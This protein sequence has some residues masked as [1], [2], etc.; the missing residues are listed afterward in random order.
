MKRLLAFLFGLSAMCGSLAADDWDPNDDSF[1]PSIQS[2]VIGDSSWLGDPSPFLFT[3]L[4]R[5]GYTHV[6]QVNW[7]GFD[8][9]VQ[10]SLMVPQKDGETEPPSGGMLLLNGAQAV[11]LI[12]ILEAA[13]KEDPKEERISIKTGMKEADWAL[14]GTIEDRQ[15]FIQLESKSKDQVD[16]YRFSINASKKLLGAIR[17]SLEKLE[18]TPTK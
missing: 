1:D 7:D 3:G 6:N 16:I 4:E 11:E 8:P 15:R 12:R 18:S 5:T 9:S 13:A 14:T 17:H 2:V 10:I